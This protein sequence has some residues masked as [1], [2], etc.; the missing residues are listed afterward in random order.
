MGYTARMAD[1]HK[2]WGK[3]SAADHRECMGN[4]K[5]VLKRS[6]SL[7]QGKTDCLHALIIATQRS[8]VFISEA[9]GRI[10]VRCVALIAWKAPM[11][12]LMMSSIVLF[13][14]NG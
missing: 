6:I 14:E 7:Q 2:G 10:G 4:S 8:G 3:T 5:C 11:V 13:I 1:L 9:N 12:E